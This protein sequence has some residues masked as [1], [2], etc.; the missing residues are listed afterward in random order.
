MR[1]MVRGCFNMWFRGDGGRL[2]T[3]ILDPGWVKR[4]TILH[5][6]GLLAGR[7]L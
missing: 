1:M 2:F 4:Y 7:D 5:C 6:F 3:S